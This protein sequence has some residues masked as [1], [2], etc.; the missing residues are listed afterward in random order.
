VLKDGTYSA[1]FKTPLS[2]GTGIVHVAEGKIWGRDGVMTYDGS[3]EVDGDRFTAVVMTKKHTKGLPTVFG[4]DNELELKLAGTCVG[5]IATYT[6][7]AEQ[8]PGVLLEGT[9]ILCEQQPRASVAN[10]PMPNFDP[11]KL[12]KLPKRRR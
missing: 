11:K 8:F 5:R 9:L 3:C 12:P 2:Q 10:E 4:D 6:G 1:W 7:T